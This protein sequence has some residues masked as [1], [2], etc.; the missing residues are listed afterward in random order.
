MAIQG[1][2]TRTKR[3]RIHWATRAFVIGTVSAAI[4][5][6][7]WAGWAARI[8]HF[9]W[10]YWHQS[11]P[12][13]PQ[14]LALQGVLVRWACSTPITTTAWFMTLA[15]GLS[16]SALAYAWEEWSSRP[17]DNSKANIRE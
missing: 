3:S 8:W 15:T 10:L 13:A 9:E 2:T 16:I 17:M 4:S 6:S 5:L 11:A 12:L 7:L 14:H 1:V